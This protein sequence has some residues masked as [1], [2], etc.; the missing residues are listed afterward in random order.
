[1]TLG[2]AAPAILK[3]KGLGAFG[4]TA[5]GTGLVGG[6]LMWGYGLWWFAM[7][8]P[9]TLRYL[10]DGLPFNLG[11]WGYTFPI[12]VYAVATL[13]PGTL[14]PLTVITG[15]GHGL[16]ALLALVWIVVAARTLH[17]M[18]LDG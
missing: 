7:A 8:A 15:F 5:G 10:R 9:I 17:G 1:M 2:Q 11:W 14:V 3:A 12:G 6:M 13:K 16:V 4:A 18:M